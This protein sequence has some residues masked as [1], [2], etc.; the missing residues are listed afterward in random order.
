MTII[1]IMVYSAG[2]KWLPRKIVQ[3]TGPVSFVVKLEKG[4]VW[5]RHINQIRKDLKTKV[6]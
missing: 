5:R 3:Q 1:A 2:Q 6:L 4:K